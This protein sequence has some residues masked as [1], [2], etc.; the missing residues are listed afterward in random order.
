[1]QGSPAAGAWNRHRAAEPDEPTWTD[2]LWFAEFGWR[3]GGLRLAPRDAMG[4]SLLV[5]VTE[6]LTI[7][8]EQTLRRW[9]MCS[10]EGLV[11]LTIWRLVSVDMTLMSALLGLISGQNVSFLQAIAGSTVPAK[12]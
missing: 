3:G 1:M 9:T 5:A 8:R 12:F 7:L 4:G 6:A 11:D 2:A 10:M